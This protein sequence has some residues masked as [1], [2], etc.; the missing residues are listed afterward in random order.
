MNRSLALIV[1][2][3]TLVPWAYFAYVLAVAQGLIVPFVDELD[4]FL[5]LPILVL[6]LEGALIAFYLIH[7]VRTDRMSADKKALWAVLLLFAN[8]LAMPFYWYFYMRPQADGVNP[9][10]LNASR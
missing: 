2:A 6:V 7:L 8:L 9:H 1:A 10:S 3:L 5:W 4:I